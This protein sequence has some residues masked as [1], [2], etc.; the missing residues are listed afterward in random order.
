MR[1]APIHAETNTL[2]CIHTQLT[3]TLCTDELTNTLCTDE[4]TDIIRVQQL[5]QALRYKA[6]VHRDK[7]KETFRYKTINYS[8]INIMLNNTSCRPDRQGFDVFSSFVDIRYHVLTDLSLNSFV[9]LLA[10]KGIIAHEV[11]WQ[12]PVVW[13][14]FTKTFV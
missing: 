12:T 13:N 11:K 9:L 14:S 8:D 3:N 7:M 5:I 4:L 10:C 2:I 6:A 1:Q